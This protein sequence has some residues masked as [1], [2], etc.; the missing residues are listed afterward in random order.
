MERAV[1]FA[2]L[3]DAIVST[4]M[5]VRFAIKQTRMI[6][7]T[8]YR[9]RAESLKL[10]CGIALLLR[11]RAAGETVTIP[12]YVRRSKA[13]VMDADDKWISCMEW[14]R[15]VE[16]RGIESV[17]LC[18]QMAGVTYPS[19]YLEPESPKVCPDDP[20]V[21]AVM[22]DGTVATYSE[23]LGTWVGEWKG[24]IEAV[25][26]R[27]PDPSNGIRAAVCDLEVFARKLYDWRRDEF[28]VSVDSQPAELFGPVLDTLDGKLLDAEFCHDTVGLAYYEDRELIATL[29]MERSRVYRA[30]II[31][32][33]LSEM[34]D[35]MG[36]P[37]DGVPTDLKEQ[38]GR[39]KRELNRQT[40][41][42]CYFAINGA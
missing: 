10:T 12:D 24:S 30:S 6:K 28:G 39:L 31:G 13:M 7:E 4:L 5:G 17:W 3:A 32:R 33:V 21:A 19:Y 20:A 37:F 41:L 40:A 42:G 36:G 29:P 35:R 15:E 38:Y 11:I 9:V 18:D 34:Y 16:S 2:Y 23:T 14:M 26:P 27:V 25:V 8:M 22:P 1:L